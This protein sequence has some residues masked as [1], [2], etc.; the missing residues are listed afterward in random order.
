MGIK[1]T[2]AD[3]YFSLAV[4]ETAHYTCENCG[5]QGR[6]E[7][8]HLVGRREAATRWDT[9]NALSLCHFCHRRF[10]E[11]PKDFTDWVELNWPGRWDILN[12]KRRVIVKNNEA[13]RKEVAAH[14]RKEL[15]KLKDDPTYV[16][17]SWI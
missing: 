4:R 8:A 13:T 17:I 9:Y 10:T 15:Q 5:K 3:K 6:T 16:I 7:C 14:Y 12:E 1:I 11:C 2:S